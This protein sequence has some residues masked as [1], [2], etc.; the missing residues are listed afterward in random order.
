MR[1]RGVWGAAAAGGVAVS[2]AERGDGGA[3][4]EDRSTERACTGYRKFEVRCAGGRGYGDDA[5]ACE[6]GLARVGVELV[7]AGS[8]LG[9]EEEAL[10]ATWLEVQRRSSPVA[11]MLLIAPRHTDRF[12]EVFALIGAQGVCAGAMQFAARCG[13]RKLYGGECGVVAGY[14][15]GP[16]FYVLG[17]CRWLLSVGVW[18]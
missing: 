8:T 1:L 12:D 5:A 11:S 4:G 13:R 15:R 10:L 7:V 3:A 9:G 18:W 6:S 17:R 14:D 2:G 16:G